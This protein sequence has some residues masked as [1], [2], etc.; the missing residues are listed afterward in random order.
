MNS[1]YLYS[2]ISRQGHHDSLRR[3]RELE[4]K[5]PCYIG[6]IMEIRELHPGMGLRK[7]YEQFE[8][9][10]IGRDAFVSLGLREGF[11]LKRVGSPHKTTIAVK[12]H[13][14]KN[15]LENKRLTDVNQVW[16]SD[17]F[18]FPLNNRHYYIVLIMDLYSRKIVGY[19]VA[20]N[21]RAEN[22]I[23]ALKMAF[24]IRGIGDYKKSLIHHSDRGSQYVS[25]NYTNLLED[26]GVRISMCRNVLENAHSERVNGTIK[27][28]YLGNWTITNFKELEVATKRAVDN[29]NNRR[30][31]SLGTTP[32]LFEV[33]IKGIPKNERKKLE[34][35]TM[36][37]E[38]ENP[39]QYKLNFQ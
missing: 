34:I 2:G 6:L 9:E 8:P 31:F 4:D 37:K 1:V 27:N 15:L 11:R 23:N 13:R 36:N 22:N 12:N 17:L 30:H 16:V 24:T 5:I 20:G 19:S 38:I 26:Y 39:L 28:E 14:Y 29:Y 7:M 3:E 33:K 25:D 35:F 32:E 10:G 21:M 18:Y